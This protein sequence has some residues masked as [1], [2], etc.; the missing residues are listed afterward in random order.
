MNA[1]TKDIRRETRICGSLGELKWDGS[2]ENDL[3]VTIFNEQQKLG[4]APPTY[5]KPDMVAPPVKTG[6]H[7]GADFFLMNAFVKAIAEGES[8]YIGTGV[9][10]S[11][12]S[13]KLVFAAEQ[14]RKNHGIVI[15]L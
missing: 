12:S 2:A 6:G 4:Q 8:K 1:F 11:L 3:V 13:H 5:I 10:G 14:S 7:G 15:N 9:E